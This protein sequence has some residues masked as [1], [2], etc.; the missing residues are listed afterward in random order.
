MLQQRAMKA[1]TQSVHPA[2]A[3]FNSFGVFQNS[4][5]FR[6]LK[7][8]TKACQGLLRCVLSAHTYIYQQASIALVNLQLSPSIASQMITKLAVD[9]VLEASWQQ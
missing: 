5:C 4:T 2:G 3:I 7:K 8:F 9:S 1:P 6:S